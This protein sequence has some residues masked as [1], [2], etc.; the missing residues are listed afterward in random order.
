MNLFISSIRQYLQ[1]AFKE[2]ELEKEK[3]IINQEFEKQK[4]EVITELNKKTKPKGFEVVESSNGVFMLP[5]VNG[6]TLSQG[7]FEKLDSKIKIEFENKS[8]NIQDDI[9]E[10]LASI[11]ELEIKK[12]GNLKDWQR[13][14]AD[15]VIDKCL[16]PIIDK[17]KSN[18]KI[19]Y[20]LRT[21]KEDVL[22][23]LDEFLKRDFSDQQA[24][25]MQQQKKPWENYEVNLF[26]DN[27]ETLGAPVIMDI[28]YTFEN[29]FGKVDYENKYGALVTDYKKIKA[30][31][32]T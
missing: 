18:K 24:N 28:N 30:R 3:G 20:F 32:I 14:I 31:I 27:S 21:V 23:N 11:K 13:Q 6:V 1:N 29:I 25:Q 22:D 4:K 19:L 8:K 16:I 2:D 7:D 12:D 5:V 15:R 17:F 10:A 26:V 9:F